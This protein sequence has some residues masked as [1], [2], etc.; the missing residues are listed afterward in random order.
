MKKYYSMKTT[1]HF[2]YLLCIMIAFSCE[3][4]SSTIPGNHDKQGFDNAI[5]KHQY[6]NEEIFPGE[7]IGIYDRWRLDGIGGGFTG[8][9]YSPDFEQLV[10]EEIGIFKFYRNDSLLAY[11]KIE[12]KEQ[13]ENGLKVSFLL[14]S[15]LSKMDFFDMEKYVYLNDSLLVLYA[16]CC[17]RFNYYF[18]RC[19]EYSKS[20]YY[21]E[22]P[23]LDNVLITPISVPEGK[24]LRSVFFTDMQNGYVLCTDN[25]IL[26]TGD[27]GDS[28]LEYNTGTDLPLYSFFFLDENI[29]F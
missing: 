18:T 21:Q 16:P 27:G 5:N 28:W 17:D 12:I 25:T 13:N 6:Y 3:K 23:Q 8:G 11:G 29:G 9:G 7:Y 22:N 20:I 14:D 4:D 24:T 1:T 26:K 10:I 2:L 15:S 19:A